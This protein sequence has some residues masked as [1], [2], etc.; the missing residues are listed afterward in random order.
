MIERIAR[1][2]QHRDARVPAPPSSPKALPSAGDRA[3]VARAHHSI[4]IADV[5]P[6]LQRVRG[7]HAQDLAG[8]QAGLDGSSAFGQITPAVA[9]MASLPATSPTRARRYLSMIST[10]LR[11]GPKTIVAP[12]RAR[13]PLRDSRFA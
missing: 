10:E 6:E 7:D 3:R 2:N 1:T 8:A 5:D 11:E 9:M 12:W 13:D 4:Q